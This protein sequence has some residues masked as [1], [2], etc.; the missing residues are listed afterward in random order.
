MEEKQKKNNIVDFGNKLGE[1]ASEIGNKF[2]ESAKH[3]FD[4]IN[5]FK[6]ST[7]RDKEFFKCEK[8]KDIQVIGAINNIKDDKLKAE[9]LNGFFNSSN[10]KALEIEKIHTVKYLAGAVIM[11]TVAVILNQNNKN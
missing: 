5:F 3:A 6:H 7:K 1:K 9:T 2:S 10:Q 4:N 8:E 11:G